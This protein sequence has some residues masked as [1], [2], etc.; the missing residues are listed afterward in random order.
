VNNADIR[1]IAL[2]LDGTIVNEQQQ[3][4]AATRETVAA[5]RARGIDVILAS[6]RSYGSMLPYAHE[7]ELDEVLIALN[8]GTLGHSRRGGLRA[9]QLLRAEQIDHVVQRLQIERM[10]FVLFGLDG[11]YGLR[12]AVDAEALT[13]YGEPPVQFVADLTQVSHPLKIL[14]FERP[15]RREERLRPLMEPL[16]DQ[17]RT[18]HDFLE[19]IPPG[20]SKGAALRGLLAERGIAAAQVLAIGDGYNDI[21]LFEVAGTSVAMGNAAAAVK[22]AARSVTASCAQDGAALALQRLVL[23]A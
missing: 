16:V 13:G 6:G 14:A 5:C 8:G 2:D 18:G 11:L 20:I 3:I 4:S 12:G 23:S 22:Q 9:Q 19:W 7:L 1:L 21:S 17:V 15:G 10:P